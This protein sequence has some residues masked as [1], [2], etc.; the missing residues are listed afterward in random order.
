MRISEK[1]LWLRMSSKRLGSAKAKGPGASGSGGG[2][3]GR[4][5]LAASNGSDAQGFSAGL[6]QQTKAMRPPGFRALR[7]LAKAAT[8]ASKNITPKREKIRSKSG[9]KG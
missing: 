8:G 3:S 9:V 5:G 6:R 1:P 4:N 7:I 2:S